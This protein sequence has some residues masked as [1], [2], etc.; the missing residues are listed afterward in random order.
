MWPL[1]LRHATTPARSASQD[2]IR[3]WLD[4]G[5]F[6][7][8]VYSRHNQDVTNTANDTLHVGTH[9]AGEKKLLAAKTAHTRIPRSRLQ[10]SPFRKEN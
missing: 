10:D 4:R 6:S 2:Q 9:Q 7:I 8:R 3:A 1:L 5:K